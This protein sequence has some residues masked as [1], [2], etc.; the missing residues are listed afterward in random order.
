M[1]I[2]DLRAEV[3]GHDLFT[4]ASFGLRTGDRVGVVGPNGVGKSTLLRILA[5][6]READGGEVVFRD[7]TRVAWLEQEPTWAPAPAL[8]VLLD[9]APEAREDEAHRLL[10]L[11]AV[12]PDHRTDAMSPGQRRR[13]A[14]GRT[15]LAPAEILLLDEPT[16]HLDVEMIDWL[17]QELSRFSGA[18]VMVTHDRY[19]LERVTNRMLDLHRIDAGPARVHWHEGS[20]ASLLEAR[21]ERADREER[22]AQRA[23]SRLTKEIAWLRRQPRARTSKPRFRVE[24]VEQLR[25]R[26]TLDAPAATLEL[27][28]GR[29]RLGNDVVEVTDARVHRGDTLVLDDVTLTI[30]PGERVGIVGPN[31]AGKSTL[32]EVLAGH[33]PVDAGTVRIGSTVQFGVYT[34]DSDLGD[35]DVSVLDSITAIGSHIPL[36]DGST[37]PATSLAE[38]FGFEGRLL[39]TPVNRLSGGERRRLALLHLLV[40]APNVL[41]L[42]E[43]TNDLDLDTLTALEDHLDGFAGTLVVASHDRFVLDRLTDRVLAV[44]DTRVTAFNDLEAYRAARRS[45]SRSGPSS[46]TTDP[47][48]AGGS[49]SNRARQDARRRRRSLESRVEQLTARRDTIHARMAES[50]AD[51]AVLSE[52]QSELADVVE[53]L[54]T[55][56]EE[57]LAAAELEESLG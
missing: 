53:Q 5:G 49:P 54:G 45:S 52:L 32:L 48:P 18:L 12:D 8:Q 30:G 7:G 43:P 28:T 20:Y 1:S 39:N 10:H 31:G 14:L 3:D 56:E 44:G 29:R 6:D 4:S 50:A 36:A 46:P 9:G 2:A 40:T 26:A 55:V 38:R 33:R 42:D 25:D 51:H 16:N 34:Q 22:D 41:L 27:G 23:R 13:V 24:Q 19:L 47:T 11:L 17:E 35:E 15:L 21:M 37:L 57:W